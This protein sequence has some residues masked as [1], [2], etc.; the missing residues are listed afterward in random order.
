MAI[1]LRDYFDKVIVINLER[2]PERLTTFIEHCAS[3]RI[4]GIDVVQAIDGNTLQ[5]HSRISKGALGLIMTTIQIVREAKEQGAKS[6]LLLEDDVYFREQIEYLATL[7]NEM[8][9]DCQ[10]LYLGGHHIQQPKRLTEHV[11][12][13]VQVFTTHSYVIYESLYDTILSDLADVYRTDLQIDLYFSQLQQRVPAYCFIPSITGQRADY[14]DIENRWT[15]YNDNMDENLIFENWPKRYLSIAIPCHDMGNKGDYLDQ[16]LEKLSVQSFRDFNVIVS[17]H[18]TT[19]YI[20]NVCNYWKDKGLDVHYIRKDYE[21]DNASS[22]INNAIRYSNGT[23]IK[24]LF[25]D[26]YLYDEWSLQKTVNIIKANPNN[27]WFASACQHSEDGETCIREFQPKWNPDIIKGVNTISSPSVITIKN[28]YS[29]TY[30]DLN[31]CWLM[32]VDWYYRMHKE[33]GE[34][35]YIKDIT[36]VNRLHPYQLTNQLTQEAKDKE[37]FIIKRKYS[38]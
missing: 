13:C 23:Y 4:S 28:G 25:Q 33:Y 19:P 12:R 24:L 29:N 6:V 36:V 7:L 10:L 37:H 9:Q 15:D 18:S 20:E 17:D 16:S 21:R 26:D 8:P 2:R 22:N 5:P 27:R 38:L 3:L 11:A 34:P 1:N 30:F 31:L 35:V 32:D 14:S